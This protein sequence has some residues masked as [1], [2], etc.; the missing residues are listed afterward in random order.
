MES[1]GVAPPDSI[2]AES[3]VFEKNDLVLALLHFF[4][5]QRRARERVS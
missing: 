1:T 2:N 5:Q 4:S 3:D